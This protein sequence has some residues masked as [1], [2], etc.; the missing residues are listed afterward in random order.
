MRKFIK[1]F[2]VPY[3]NGEQSNISLLEIRRFRSP[4]RRVLPGFLENPQRFSGKSKRVSGEKPF[5][6][7]ARKPNDGFSQ[8]RTT[9][10]GFLKNL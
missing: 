1:Y 9:F 10:Q 4:A 7:V 3:C 5:P 6:R 2:L 8:L